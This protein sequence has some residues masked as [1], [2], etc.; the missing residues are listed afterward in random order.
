MSYLLAELQ[1]V[2]LAIGVD[3]DPLLNIRSGIDGVLGA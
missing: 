1:L 3:A 2:G